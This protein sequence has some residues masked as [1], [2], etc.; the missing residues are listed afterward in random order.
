MNVAVRRGAAGVTAVLLAVLLVG[1]SR[2]P[3]AWVRVEDAQLRLAWQFQSAPVSRCR[4]ATAEELA[5][6]PEHMRQRTI[7]ERA[8]RPY[9]LE[10][11]VDGIARA[12]DT[13]RARG[14]RADRP[15]G[16]FQQLALAPGR[17]AVHVAFTPLA[18]PSDSAGAAVPAPPVV[19]T[20]VTFAPRQV[21][22]VTYDEERRVLALRNR[23]PD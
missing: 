7:C 13:V 22:L 6:L 2:V 8:L 10:V 11:A 5:K 23:L 21:W 14:A 18:L 4:T 15:L 9:R 1:L 16:V 3:F 12:D 20:T 17:H 19:D